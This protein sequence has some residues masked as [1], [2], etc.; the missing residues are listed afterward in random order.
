MS[1]RLWEVG[2][3][4]YFSRI[5]RFL[6]EVP[7][8]I[9]LRWWRRRNNDM[10]CPKRRWGHFMIAWLTDHNWRP[11]H[12][13]AIHWGRIHCPHHHGLR[14]IVSVWG[15]LGIRI[16]HISIII[17]VAFKLR[18]RLHSI[19]V[20]NFLTA[21]EGNICILRIL[22]LFLFFLFPFLISSSNTAN[23]NYYNHQ[24]G[25]NGKDDD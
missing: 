5:I 24:K 18:R 8:I 16:R 1:E 17:C 11:I 19:S 20:L 12:R 25:N 9:L 14:I 21:L 13:R 4:R 15:R 3:K 23:S 2:S 10:M 22:L 6:S 7:V